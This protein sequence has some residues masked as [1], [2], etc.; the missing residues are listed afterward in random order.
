MRWVACARAVS[1][2]D[3]TSFAPS[4]R[5]IR[6][7][8]QL[9]SGSK[10]CATVEIRDHACVAAPALQPPGDQRCLDALRRDQ[11]DRLAGQIGRRQCSLIAAMALGS[12]KR[13]RH[14]EG[15][16]GT[17][18]AFQRDAAAHPLDDA[19]GDAQA[20]SGAAIASGDALVGLL[21]FAED[22]GLGFRR[23]ADAGVAHQETD[24]I[25]P[26]AGLD[27]QGHAAGRGELDG[28]AGEIE[29]HLPQSRRVA[30]HF[31][32]QPLVDIGRDLEFSRLRPRRQQFGDVL[33]QGGQ[34]KR[35][36]FEIDLAGFDLGII[37]KFLDQREQ[38]VAGAF[39]RP[40]IGH[41]LR[42][43]RRIQQQS[44]HADDAI[45]RRADF[46]RRHREETRL[47]AVGGVGLIAGFGKGALGLGAV[48][49]VAADTLHLG[50][51]ARIAAYQT[52]APGD[53]SRSDRTCDLLVVNPCTVRL[54]RRVA[55]FEDLEREGAADQHVAGTL[56]QS[57]IGVV[58]EGDTAFGVAQHDQVALRFEQAAGALFGLLQFPIA[59]GQR[60]VMQRDL[61]DL[62]A[63][64]AQPDAQ[65][66][67][68]DAGQR[69]QEAGA[70]GKGV[71]VIAG[72]FGS[73]S[74]DE[75]IR[76]AESGREDHE[77]AD[78]E[79]EP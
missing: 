39:H 58:D 75:T 28:V 20:K 71:R 63:H 46:V 13:D 35:A 4:A 22:P 45:Q 41:L 44:A 30:D 67:E 50:G 56:G 65:G 37:Q 42:R 8:C 10:A 25:G 1:A 15:R 60:F 27:D 36:M 5:S 70:D 3:S 6:T 29:Q 73:A 62:L 43:Q 2:S 61:A 53:P 52:F 54:Q 12:G 26:D 68:R 51:P 66:R 59:I 55:L 64:P 78:S 21:E 33:D 34:R 48:G 69:K 24:F 19:L 77:R 14:L 38:G 49:D 17:W 72:I 7:A 11:H 47:G 32:R 76:A 23:D 18:G 31:H 16:T 74:D 79:D 9:R 57:A 40:G